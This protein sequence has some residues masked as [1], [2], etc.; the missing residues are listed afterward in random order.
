ML[1]VRILGNLWVGRYLKSLAN[2]TVPGFASG[3]LV[4]LFSRT[5]ALLGG[6]FV[7]SLHLSLT[8]VTPGALVA[9]IP[10]VASRYGFNVFNMLGIN[11]ILKK[12]TVL[13]RFKGRPWFTASFLVT[14]ILAAFVQL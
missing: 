13:K 6:L 11:K 3:L 1:L 9:D 12:S 8:G 14:F 10:Q 5:L 7:F 2:L 4:A